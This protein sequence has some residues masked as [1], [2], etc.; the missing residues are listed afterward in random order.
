MGCGG[1]SSLGKEQGASLSCCRVPGEVTVRSPSMAPVSK[2]FPGAREA[3]PLGRRGL[4]KERVKGA[5][6][7]GVQ[8]PLLCCSFICE[9][10]RL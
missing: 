5:M 2:V 6:W 8:S 10:G 4:R 7:K 9:V 3:F 1:R